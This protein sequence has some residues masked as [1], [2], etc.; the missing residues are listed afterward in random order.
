MVNTGLPSSAINTL[1]ADNSILFAGT[2]GDGVFLSSDNGENWNS[3]NSGL[4]NYS[5]IRSLFVSGNYLYAGISNGGIWRRPLSEMITSI[6]ETPEILP[7]QFILEQNYPNPFNPSTVISYQLPVSGDVT[8]KVYD[9]LGNEI[10]TL[11][12]EYKPAGS[13]E[14]EFNA[15]SHSGE[16]RNLPS[17]TY[18]YQLRAGSFVETKKMILMK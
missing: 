16:V 15:S 8:L 12:D 13:Y 11:V 9:V 6:K 4:P 18:F 10:A 14:F 1:V 5:L 7:A 3:V 17:G 2:C